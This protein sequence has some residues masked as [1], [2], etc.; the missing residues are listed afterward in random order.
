MGNS[1][2]PYLPKSLK[3]KNTGSIGHIAATINYVKVGI[4]FHLPV[5]I[6]LVHTVKERMASTL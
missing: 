3:T 2:W 6:F 5:V 1:V 4:S